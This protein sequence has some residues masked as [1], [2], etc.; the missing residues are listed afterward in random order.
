MISTRSLTCTVS[1]G[2]ISALDHKVA[3]DA[4]ERRAF[5]VQLVTRSAGAL[6]THTERQKV[7]GGFGHS[8]GIQ[9]H[10]NATGVLASNGNVEKHL[11]C[12]VKSA[13]RGNDD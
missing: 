3:N 4:V 13:L 9:E 1:A 5:V 7:G 2:E 6:V 8:V 11:M 10:H 12:K